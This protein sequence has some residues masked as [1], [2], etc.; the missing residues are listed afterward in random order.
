MK[1]LS[2][3]KSPEIVL[4]E[5]TWN[6]KY[7]IGNAQIDAEHQ[8]LIELAN[9][10]ATFASH[11]EKVARVRKD[12]LALYE[13]M[14]VHFQHENEY[15]LQLG[16]PRYEEHKKQHE[17]ILTAMNAIIKHSDNLDALV[18]KLKQLMHAWVRGHVLAQDPRIAPPGKPE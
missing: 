1:R 14:R 10:I 12:I 7:S 9:D 15:M 16:Y 2:R 17:E 6:A 18:Y 11:G 3:S 5:F 8:G 13:H 4:S